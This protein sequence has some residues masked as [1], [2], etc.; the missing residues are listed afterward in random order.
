MPP[1]GDSAVRKGQPQGI[2]INWANGAF[3][4]TSRT[5]PAAASPLPLWALCVV[6]S[7][8]FKIHQAKQVMNGN[9]GGGEGGH[10]DFLRPALTPCWLHVSPSLF[11]K[12]SKPQA[13]SPWQG[14]RLLLQAA[15]S[16]SEPP[17]TAL[18]Q[19]LLQSPRQRLVGTEEASNQGTS[20]IHGTKQDNLGT[21]E[22]GG[23]E[24]PARP[25][26]LK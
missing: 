3:P 8:H 6:T 26:N 25:P 10:L 15:L 22:Q 20:E 9:W 11:F 24:Q 13:R 18:P 2:L 21:E 5:R 1:P 12:A 4:F 17:D 14:G 19:K 7:L 16:I 23:P